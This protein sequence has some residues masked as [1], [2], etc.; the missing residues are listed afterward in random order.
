M[1]I[2]IK[3]CILKQ[4]VNQSAR[5]YKTFTSNVRITKHN[6]QLTGTFKHV[7]QLI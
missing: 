5:F 1:H 4:L 6:Q 7:W 3:Q 2:T